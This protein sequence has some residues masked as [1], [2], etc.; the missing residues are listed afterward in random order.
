MK[1][2]IFLIKSV[3]KKTT[4]VSQQKSHKIRTV[5]S[6]DYSGKVERGS[7]GELWQVGDGIKKSKKAKKAQAK[8]E[9]GAILLI[10]MLFTLPFY[11]SA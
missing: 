8:N 6:D 11:S 4:K 9:E 2:K 5:F 3:H 1:A 10:Q 7:L